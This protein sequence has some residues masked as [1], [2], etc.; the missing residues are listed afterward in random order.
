[1]NVESLPTAE[2][3][4]TFEPLELAFQLGLAL[5]L[6]FLIGLQRERSKSGFG[7]RT[8]PLITVFGMLCALLSTLFGS[9]L[10]PVGL[11]CLM[12]IGVATSLTKSYLLRQWW[13][14]QTENDRNN[15]GNKNNAGNIE[16]ETAGTTTAALPGP[17]RKTPTVPDFGTTTL[18]TMLVMFCIGALLVNPKWNLLAMEITGIMAIILQFKLELHQVADKLGES[19][20]RAIMQFVMISFI[21]LPVLPNH[22]YGPYGIFNPYETWLMVVLIVGVSLGGYICYK[23]FGENTGILLGGFF[24]GAI[25]SMATTI[26]YARMTKAKTVTPKVAGVVIMIASTVLLLR[27]LILVAIVSEQFFLRC[28]Q[29]VLAFMVFC[30]IPAFVAWRGIGNGTSSVQTHTNPTQWQSALTFGLL[31]AAIAGA[32]KIASSELGTDGLYLVAGV[33]GLTDTTAVTLS[34]ARLSL[35]NPAILEN[36]WRVIIICSLTNLLFKWLTVWCLAGRTL[37]LNVFKL[38]LIP[39]LAGIAILCWWP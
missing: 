23:F 10:L 24:G 34:T 30:S 25:S 1:M 11:F 5:I 12:I 9:W 28:W 3:L 16:G 27:L 4:H 18:V 39:A 17:E 36:G 15:D 20:M 37:A 6:G 7:I 21:I 19:D 2:S 32:M 8:F 33:S 13:L 29:P 22:D 38:F 35:N 14:R 26:S 31:Y